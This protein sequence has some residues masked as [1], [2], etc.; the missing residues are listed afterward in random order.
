MMARMSRRRINR[1][2]RPRLVPPALD[3]QFAMDTRATIASVITRRTRLMS[4]NRFDG[5]G[6]TALR[7]R[8]LGTRYRA[9]CT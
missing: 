1:S 6:S 4:S 5:N 3:F 7:T 2:M 9:R 8:A